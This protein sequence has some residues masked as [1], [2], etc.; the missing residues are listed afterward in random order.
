MASVISGVTGSGD[1]ASG[2]SDVT[3][4]VVGIS[5]GSI[6]SITAAGIAVIGVTGVV[7][8]TTSGGIPVMHRAAGCVAVRSEPAAPIG[9]TA[10]VAACV[11]FID[12]YP[13][14]YPIIPRIQPSAGPFCGDRLF[15]FPA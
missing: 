12:L 9:G 11:A 15:I 7:A 10:T 2:V 1:A 14:G 8:T 6:G 4:S 5:V 13:H 3:D